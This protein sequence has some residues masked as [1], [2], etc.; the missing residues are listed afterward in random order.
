VLLTI[1]DSLRSLFARC[2]QLA[3]TWCASTLRNPFV[4]TT[5]AWRIEE[6][7]APIELCD[8]FG[9]AALVRSAGSQGSKQLVYAKVGV[10]M[11]LEQASKVLEEVNQPVPWC[12]A[13]A[14]FLL[15]EPQLG[16][17]PSVCAGEAR[18]ER[19]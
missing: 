14:V 9:L 11:R 2:E 17:V 1:R 13:L 7:E 15:A 8:S 19:R 4:V 16:D 5:T 18:L 6:A 10:P 3:G 12:F